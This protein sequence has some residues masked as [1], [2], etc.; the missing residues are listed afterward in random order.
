MQVKNTKQ[1]HEVLATYQWSL[2]QVSLGH[3]E[4]ITNWDSSSTWQ[5]SHFR[6]LS[7]NL[8][9]VVYLADHAWPGEVLLIS[10]VQSA[11]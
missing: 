11:T 3:V 9:W 7:T 6:E 2:G 4:Q 1:R 5:N 10:S 8:K